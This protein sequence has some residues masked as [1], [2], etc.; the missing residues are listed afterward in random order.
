[1]AAA[2]EQQAR[3]RRQQTEE[4]QFSSRPQL[5]EIVPAVAGPRVQ[6]TSNADRRLRSAAAAADE[7]RG[8]REAGMRRQ[9]P[10][11]ADAGIDVI[12]GVDAGG[13][14]GDFRL[15]VAVKHRKSIQAADEPRR[16]GEN[17]PTEYQL[18]DTD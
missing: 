18:S 4:H 12:G 7:R 9:K 6:A 10:S 2:V 17:R 5:H 14:W 13:G 3:Q 1:M 15:L 11:D 8:Q 16:D